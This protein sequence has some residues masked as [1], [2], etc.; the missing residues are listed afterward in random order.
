MYEGAYR[1]TNP[2]EVIVDLRWK[3]QDL[4]LIPVTDAVLLR[5]AE[6][7]AQLRQRGKPRT[8]FDLLIAATALQHD[9]T[10]VTRNAR[11]FDD[12]PDLRVIEL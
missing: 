9:L 4:A 8:D 2:E 11:D 3:L 6:V 1:H 10:L 7:R 5:F 12:I